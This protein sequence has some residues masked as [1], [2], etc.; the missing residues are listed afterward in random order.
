MH[1]I[2]AYSRIVLD[3]YGLL[4]AVRDDPE[5]RHIPM[6]LLTARVSDNNRVEGIVGPVCPF[7]GLGAQHLHSFL[8]QTTF[9]RNRSP[10]ESSWLVQIFTFSLANESDKWNSCLSTGVFRGSPA[11]CLIFRNHRERSS[12]LQRLMDLTPV[13]IFR[14]DTSG[15]LVYCNERFKQLSGLPKD[16]SIIGESLAEWWALIFSKMLD[17]YTISRMANIDPESKAAAEEF[18]R[19]GLDNSG[20]DA[21]HLRFKNG[22]WVKAQAAPVTIPY[23]GWVG[24]VGTLTDMTLTR[25]E[26]NRSARSRLTL[27]LTKAV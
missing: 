12:E 15:H 14:I 19:D 6:I 18:V 13:G 11:T 25:Y 26:N 2:E 3:G 20:I 5:L 24:L 21:V 27:E 4:A 10:Q 7:P 8:G 1:T 16:Y 9:F 23:S 17:T 22:I